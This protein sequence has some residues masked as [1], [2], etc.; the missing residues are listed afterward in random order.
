MSGCTYL[1]IDGE[2]LHRRYREAADKWFGAGVTK[3]ID[4][5]RL[6]SNYPA[7]RTF[8]YDCVDDGKATNESL[9]DLEGRVMAQ[10][11][12]LSRI[13]AIVRLGS[14]TGTPERIC[15]RSV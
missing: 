6:Q 11:D 15:V 3:T 8:Y 1:F 4:F 7:E 2:Y 5:G 14:V 9:S 10:V 12:Y 13:P